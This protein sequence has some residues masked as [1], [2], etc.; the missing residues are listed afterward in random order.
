MQFARNIS[1]LDNG[2]VQTFITLR[3][4]LDFALRVAEETPLLS[5]LN[6]MHDPRGKSY[7]GSHQFTEFGIGPYH[8]YPMHLRKQRTLV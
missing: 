8:E 5:H 4:V 6:L 2:S 1:P 7:F 3:Q